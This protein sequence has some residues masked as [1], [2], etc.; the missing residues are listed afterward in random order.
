MVLLSVLGALVVVALLGVGFALASSGG[1]DESADPT[2]PP[3]ISIPSVSLPPVTLPPLTVPPTPTTEPPTT[4][5]TVTGEP[6]ETATVDEYCD[7]V[8][9]LAGLLQDAIDDPFNADVDRITELGSQLG[10]TAGELLQDATPEEQARI[11]ECTQQLNTL[12]PGG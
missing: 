9:E 7:Q 6:S 10:A 3:T 12:T 11:D 4:D 8:E 2:P 1:D 5:S